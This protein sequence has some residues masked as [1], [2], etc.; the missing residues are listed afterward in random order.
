MPSIA[1]CSIPSCIPGVDVDLLA[2]I[3]ICEAGLHCQTVLSLVTCVRDLRKIDLRAKRHI[4]LQ[5]H[6]AGVPPGALNVG[7]HVLASKR[8]RYTLC[9]A[10]PSL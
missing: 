1:A 3:E 8:R 6:V 4:T 10:R 5:Q 7:S 2:V 9:E